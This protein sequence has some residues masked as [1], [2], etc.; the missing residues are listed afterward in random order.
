MLDGGGSDSS[1]PTSLD[2]VNIVFVAFNLVGNYLVTELALFLSVRA[3]FLFFFCLFLF[4]YS[5]SFLSAKRKK[6]ALSPFN[7]QTDV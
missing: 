3:G 7:K 6:A 2:H 1:I 5:G 4:I